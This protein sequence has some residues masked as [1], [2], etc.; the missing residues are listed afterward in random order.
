M[1]KKILS[2]F[3]NT[4]KQQNVEFGQVLILVIALLAYVLGDSEFLPAT[5]LILGMITLLLPAVFTPFTALWREFSRIIGIAGTSV[6]LGIVFFLVVTPVGC[7]Y[8]MLKKDSMQV[9]QFGKS[10]QSVLINREHTYTENDFIHT[11]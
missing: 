7:F 4:S 10:N 11:F 2:V 9:R 3:S 1:S 8:R 6:L 5:I